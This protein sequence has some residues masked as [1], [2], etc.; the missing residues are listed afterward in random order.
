MKSAVIF[1]NINLKGLIKSHLDDKRCPCADSQWSEWMTGMFSGDIWFEESHDAGGEKKKTHN[2]ERNEF[3]PH[4]AQLITAGPAQLAPS[5]AAH[6]SLTE[7]LMRK[8]RCRLSCLLFSPC[9]PIVRPDIWRL[10][11]VPAFLTA[12]WLRIM[13]V[14]TTFVSLTSPTAGSA[15]WKRVNRRRA[16]LCATREEGYCTNLCALMRMWHVC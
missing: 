16:G 5:A 12:R 10:Q 2:D 14:H 9:S 4:K 8:K 13:F 3:P 6:S 7:C 1:Y 15:G 11:K